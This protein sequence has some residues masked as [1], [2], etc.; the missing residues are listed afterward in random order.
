MNEK[1][2]VCA[3]MIT[4]DNPEAAR[5][6]LNCFERQTWA[7]RILILNTG[8][9]P[10][11]PD[12][13]REV[14]SR[15]RHEHVPALKENTIGEMLN[16]ANTAARAAFNP[17][18]L[19]HWA[20]TDWSHPN[21]IAEQVALLQNSEADC[22][23]YWETLFW[24]AD[25]GGLI[26]DEANASRPGKHWPMDVHRPEGE[27]WL[28]TNPIPRYGLGTSLCY[29]RK[30]WEQK[31]FETNLPESAEYMKF[32]MDRKC[33]GVSATRRQASE[34]EIRASGIHPAPGVATKDI[35]LLLTL[36]EPR[37]ICEMPSIH[38]PAAVPELMEVDGEKEWR[39]VP[40]WDDYCRNAG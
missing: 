4:E 37:M 11:L 8:A 10:F 21:R 18:I 26:F 23:G 33:V 34:E 32:V 30:T 39:R 14:L 6:A 25:R 27:T 12:H 20:D 16:H 19:I 5:R 35:G 1:P 24:A 7:T 38:Y 13:C 22:V 15:I 28:Y 3:I 9:E 2:K 40:E 17:D 29:W 31:P 36:K